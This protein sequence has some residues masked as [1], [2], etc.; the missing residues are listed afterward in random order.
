MVADAAPMSTRANN[1]TGPEA[2]IEP[3]AKSVAPLDPQQAPVTEMP[4]L[5]DQDGLLAE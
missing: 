3:V 4:R 5:S 2:D 1:R